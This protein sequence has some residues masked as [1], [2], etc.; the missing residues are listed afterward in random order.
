MK[1]CQQVCSLKYY[2][3]WTLN[4]MG[5][6]ECCL[7][8]VRPNWNL[9]LKQE[10]AYW[11]SCRGKAHVLKTPNSSKGFSKAFLKVQWGRGMVS[12]CRLLGI[13]IL[14]SEAVQVGWV[15]MFWN[16]DKTNIILYSAIFILYEWTLKI[17]TWEW[18]ILYILGNSV[19]FLLKGV[20]PVWLSTGNKARVKAEGTDLIWSQICGFFLLHAKSLHSQRPTYIS[21]SPYPLCSQLSTFWDSARHRLYSTVVFTVENTQCKWPSSRFKTILS[22]LYNNFSIIYNN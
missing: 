20:E 5:H 17:S 10:K 8:T 2:V 9:E 12:C 21:R 4:N 7:C 3:P 19:M 22:K 1:T 13:E 11:G 6:E 18:A 14:C 15:A 16:L